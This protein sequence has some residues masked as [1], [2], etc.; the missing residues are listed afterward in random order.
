MIKEIGKEIPIDNK[1]QPIMKVQMRASIYYRISFHKL[2]P[3]TMFAIHAL[4]MHCT[5]PCIG[6]SQYMTMEGKI[7]KFQCMLS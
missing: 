2:S 7:L 3:Q 4:K 6:L 1:F 5:L